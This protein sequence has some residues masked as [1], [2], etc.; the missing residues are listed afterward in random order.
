M[1][2]R[3]EICSILGKDAAPAL[4]VIRSKRKKVYRELLAMDERKALPK[5][6]TFSIAA[7]GSLAF[8]ILR[9]LYEYL[10]MVPVAVN[11]EDQEWNRVIGEYLSNKGLTASENVSNTAA[12]IFI[13]DGNTLSS[14]LF[15][16]IV[17]S[18][19]VVES[20][21]IRQ[22]EIRDEPVLGLNGTLRLLDGVLNSLI[23]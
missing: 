11:V 14:L 17:R 4:E 3:Q 7:D 2:K 23:R 8:P 6:R 9:F 15:R 22:I 18:G 10:G 12:D 20:P 13:G 5:G 1:Y 19:I 16:D 21:G